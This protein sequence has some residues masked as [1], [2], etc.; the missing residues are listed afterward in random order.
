MG[1]IKVLPDLTI[2]GHAEIF[3]AGDIVSLAD[4]GGRE[5][6]GVA[7]VALQ[8]GAYVGKMI[9]HRLS[10]PQSSAAP[11]H[12]SDRGDMAVIGRASAVARIFGIEVWGLPAWLAWV[13]IH[14]IYLV[15]FQSRIIVFVRWAF[16]Y[17]TFSRGA[18]L[19]TGAVEPGSKQSQ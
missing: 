5:L 1:R 9:R 11:F 3:V 6:P 12:Y 13:F 15:E 16:Q 2:P 18:R 4:S 10:H 17:L 7:Q 8:Q 19:I 14:L